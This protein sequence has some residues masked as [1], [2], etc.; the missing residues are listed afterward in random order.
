MS[1]DIPVTQTRIIPPRRRG[2]LLTRNR[3]LE[4][5]SDLLEK[6]LSIIT[7]PAGYGKTSLLIDFANSIEYP[8][9]WYTIDSIDRDLYRFLTYFIASIQAKF[10]E[11]GHHALASL[12]N[13]SPENLNIE[14]L[15]ATIV[16][17]VFE[18]ILEH[19]VIVLDDYH[20]VN[21]TPAVEQFISR[22]IQDVD[23]NCHLI[24]SSRTLL[25]LPDFPLMVAR[26]QVGGLSFEELAFQAEEIR[27][28]FQQNFHV[29]LSNHISEEWYHQTE[30]WITGL[31]LSTQMLENTIPDKK[32]T[33][34]A[35]GVGLTEY[36]EAI[37]NRQ[38][39]ELQ[40]FLLR[41]SLLEEFNAD[42]CEQVIGQALSLTLQNWQQMMDDVLLNNLF[43][44]PIGED[45][46]WLRYHHLFSD[47]LQNKIRN[48]YPQEVKRIQIQLAEQHV[49]D[50]DWEKAYN[51]LIGLDDKENVAQLI[52]KAGPSLIARGRTRTLEEWLKQIPSEIRISRPALISLQGAIAITN[53]EFRKSIRLFNQAIKIL[54]SENDLEQYTRTLVRRS[55]AYRFLGDHQSALKDAEETLQKTDGNS[56]LLTIRAEALRSKGV[57][58]YQQGKLLEGLEWL[59]QSLEAYQLLGNKENEAILLMET[60][61]IHQS[62]ANYA[63][64]EDNYQQALSHW[65]TTEN[66]TW[67]TNVMNNLG[68]LQHQKGDYEAAS[69]TLETALEY[70][71]IVVSPRLEAYA[72]ADIGDLYRDLHA[73]NEA[74][75]AY[76]QSY[77]IAQRIGDQLLMIYLDLAEANLARIQKRFAQA[78]DRLSTAWQMAHENKTFF[79]QCL[80]YF[81][82]GSLSICLKD[83]EKAIRNLEEAVKYFET[84]NHMLEA[85]RAHLYVSIPYFQEKNIDSAIEH[86]S[87]AFA[88]TQKNQ[89]PLIVSGYWFKEEF[90]RMQKNNRIGPIIKNYLAKIE[91]FEEELPELRRNL[92]QQATVIP[93]APPRLLI[94]A[95]GASQVKLNEKSIT[96]SEWQTQNARDLFFIL[97]A[98]PEGLSKEAIGVMFWP[99]ITPEDLKYRFKNTIYRL[100][101]AI[102]KETILFDDE[103]YRFNRSLDYE[104]DVE[105]FLREINL[106][107]FAKLKTT[108]IQHFQNALEYYKGSYLPDHDDTWVIAERERLS[109]L[110]TKVLLDLA[111]SHFEDGVF[112]KALRYTQ[113]AIDKD[114]CLESA[115]RIAMRIHAA[116]GN[117]ANIERQYQS[118]IQSLWDEISAPPS[119]QTQQLHKQL[120]K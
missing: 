26:S 86:L 35:S 104:Y 98:H 82:T 21:G 75:K 101:H 116:M 53:S 65:K 111:E 7:A 58:H 28:L 89:H 23:E 38:S 117:R 49:K 18:T 40:T 99:D 76:R 20:L 11:F 66:L 68:V 2:D 44:L 59:T 61:L 36:L 6:K 4:I 51:T 92:R 83:N 46:T 22:F 34:Q 107:K 97:L 90:L 79:E 115:H 29:T 37:L 24:I 62:I 57:C 100:R 73:A 108:K 63:E 103:L 55:A 31:L 110:H 1:K 14:H 96:I 47:F 12:Q 105:A 33:A 56:S 50:Q 74:L 70:S 106:A 87:R 72:L 19:F 48:A 41:S 13:A 27:N 81:E 45:G 42:L 77:V 39:P 113:L 120:M 112:E 119:E 114:P 69:N 88:I 85:A 5:L 71:K 64:A 80:C 3:L 15:T 10:P 93:F 32:R 52:E 78:E 30:G 16:N 43:V 118:C 25:T 109:S 102:G 94:R 91:K 84:D 54:S 95:L 9:C 60:G 17:D 67:L 8:V